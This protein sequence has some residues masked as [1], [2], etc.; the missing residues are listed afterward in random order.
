MRCRSGFRCPLSIAKSSSMRSLRS[1]R[2]ASEFTLFGQIY[3]LEAVRMGAVQKVVAPDQLLDAAVNWAAHVIAIRPMH[4][5]SAPYRQRRWLRLGISHGRR[6]AH[7]VPEIRQS[8]R[9][10]SKASPMSL[11]KGCGLTEAAIGGVTCAHRV[12]VADTEVRITGSKSELL[13][14]LAARSSVESAWRAR[15]DSNA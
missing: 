3:D 2:L 13:R 4:F 10:S 11:A 1:L 7:S 14:T 8:R 9:T 6:R 12:D 15:H 5:L